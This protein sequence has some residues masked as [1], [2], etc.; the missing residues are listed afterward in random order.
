MR[1]KWIE[2]AKASFR[3][4]TCN[5]KSVGAATMIATLLVQRRLPRRRNR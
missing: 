2:E 1:D 5:L 4:L 3:V